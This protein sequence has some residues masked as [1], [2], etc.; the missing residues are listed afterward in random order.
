MEYP[1]MPTPPRDDIT[2][3]LV[4][5]DGSVY[6]GAGI[7]AVG[8][9]VGEVCFNTAMT[10]YQ[11]ILTDPSYAGQIITFTCPHIGNVGTNADDMESARPAAR[12][13]IVRE[14]VSAPSN[15]RAEQGLCDWAKA[16]GL[17]GI[18]GVDTRRLTRQIRR[19]GAPNGVIAHA[20]DGRFDLP[21]LLAQARDWPGL[22]GM[23][24]ARS[25]TT[26]QAYEW[27]Q[28]LWRIDG[29]YGDMRAPTRHVVAMDFG[30]KYNILRN[31]ANAGARVTVVP[32]TSSFEDIMALAP[33]GVFL[34]N[35]PGDPA[36]TA[37]YALPVVRKLLESG[38][39]VFGICLGHQMLGLAMGGK[40]VKM[41]Q[42][43]RGANHPVKNLDTGRVAITSMNHALPWIAADWL[44]MSASRNCPCLTVLCAH[45]RWMEGGYFPFN[46]T[47]KPHRDRKTISICLKHSSQG[48]LLG[49]DI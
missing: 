27:T 9:A 35:G 30:I 37:S 42:G 44:K 49:R 3:A 8:N 14:P 34:S 46:N 11:E 17:I 41:H 1:K 45:W 36:A 12:G 19:E 31:L 5:A 40:T 4:L 33:D 47:L 6:W 23:E 21:A 48:L 18:S 26:G 32:A 28:T 10:G 16:Q 38:L 39:P 20:P 24:L 13:F 2:A 43:H 25:V 15:W 29:G 7:G 22:Q